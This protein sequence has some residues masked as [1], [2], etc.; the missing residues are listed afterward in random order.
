MNAARSFHDV[1]PAETHGVGKE[2]IAGVNLARLLHAFL[3]D[4]FFRRGDVFRRGIANH[5]PVHAVRVIGNELVNWPWRTA[6]G[7]GENVAERDSL[8][9]AISHSIDGLHFS[10]SSSSFIPC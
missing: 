4:A 7:D 6:S 9:F 10:I 1:G 5:D 2:K 3:D 8:P